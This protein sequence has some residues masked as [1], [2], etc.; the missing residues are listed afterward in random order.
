MIRFHVFSG[1]RFLTMGHET[2]SG[3]KRIAR[4]FLQTNPAGVGFGKSVRVTD[5][6]GRDVGEWTANAAGKAKWTGI[7]AADARGTR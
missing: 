6:L 3:A 7:V 1:G 5:E 4:T 2:L